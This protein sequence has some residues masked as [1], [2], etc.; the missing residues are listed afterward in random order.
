MYSQIHKSYMPIRAK[1]SFC[2]GCIRKSGMSERGPKRSGY[3]PRSAPLLFQL[4]S[5]SHPPGG[6]VDGRR[7]E[8]GP[9]VGGGRLSIYTSYLFCG[10]IRGGKNSARG[11]R[12]ET[13][14]P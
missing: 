3:Y 9:V 5:V 4:T 11:E 14:A 13:E 2:S 10:S 6:A 12:L 8:G 1:V 7:G